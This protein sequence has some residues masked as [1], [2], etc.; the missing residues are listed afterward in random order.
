MK[1]GF[2]THPRLP[3]GN[4]PLH[5]AGGAGGR[6][7]PEGLRVGSEAGGHVRAGPR[8]LGDVHALQR[9]LPR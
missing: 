8:L 3:G 7:E 1:P 5:G 9:P 2:P 6:R 4:D